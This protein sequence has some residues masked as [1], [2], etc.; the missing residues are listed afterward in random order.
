MEQRM[1]IFKFHLKDSPEMTAVAD[2]C[3]TSS[4]EMGWTFDMTS[5]CYGVIAGHF[6]HKA[7]L[8]LRERYE[9]EID[10]SRPPLP[11]P[12]NPK[13]DPPVPRRKLASSSPRKA[14]ECGGCSRKK[15]ADGRK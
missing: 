14:G 8:K 9:R 1:H 6:E 4:D 5:P 3:A 2:A 10:G 13:V 7:R 15:R 12:Q 11:D